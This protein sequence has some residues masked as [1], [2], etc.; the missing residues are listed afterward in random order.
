MVCKGMSAQSNLEGDGG[1]VASVHV[2]MGMAGMGTSQNMVSSRPEWV[3]YST[4]R[5]F[6]LGMLVADESKLQ[7]SFIL[8]S[9]GQVSIEMLLCFW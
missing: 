1:Y 5:E 8:D 7:L 6:G 3:E 9:D 2:V 4:D